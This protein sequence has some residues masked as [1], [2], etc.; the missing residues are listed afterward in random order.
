MPDFEDFRDVVRDALQHLQD[1]DFE[2]PALL[3]QATGCRPDTTSGPVQSQLS[4]LIR[5]LEPNSEVPLDSRAWLHFKSLH[6][7]FVLGLTQEETAEDLHMSV[8]NAQ[9]IQGEAIHVLARRLWQARSQEL[10]VERSAQAVDW[11]TQAD[12][13]LA[14]LQKTAPEAEA[15]VSELIHGVV[16]L[17]TALAAKRGVSVKVGHVLDNLVAPIHPSVLRQ[18]LITAISALVPYVAPSDLTLYATFEDGH[19]KITVQGD[20]KDGALPVHQEILGEILR[21]SESEVALHQRGDAAFLQITLPAVGERTVLVVED[22]VDMVYFYRRCTAGTVYHI[23][24]V[25]SAKEIAE[26]VERTEPDII[27]LDVM[28]P[29]VDGWQL[30]THLRERPATRSIPVVVCSV[31]KEENLALALGASAFLSKPLACHELVAA[32]DRALSRES[33]EVV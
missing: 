15:N 13:E 33:S 14:T 21:P 10:E 6:K 28:L 11:R 12:L 5:D 20:L 2:P 26:S 16:A 19:V 4:A 3:C 1:P 9:R 7:R 24:H 18:T 32:L 29:D 27:L 25:P 23:V 8:R 31:V 22:N 17:E 30:L